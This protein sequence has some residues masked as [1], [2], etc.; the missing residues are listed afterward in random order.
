MLDDDRLRAGMRAEVAASGRFDHRWIIH[1]TLKETSWLRDRR[2]T[3]FTLNRPDFTTGLNYLGEA[4][5]CLGLTDWH[6]LV[7]SHACHGDPVYGEESA[8]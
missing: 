5:S 1:A 4:M 7:L 8:F 3:A 2:A 6:C